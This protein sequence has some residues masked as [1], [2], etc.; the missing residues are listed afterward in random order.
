MAV[1]RLSANIKCR[2]SPKTKKIRQSPP[3]TN[4]VNKIPAVITFL[5]LSGR[6]SA[7]YLV[8]NRETVIGVPEQ[9]MVSK[10]AKTDSQTKTTS[11]R[12]LK[13]DDK[14]DR[15]YDLLDKPMDR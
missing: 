2:L 3:A 10:N 1:Q 14:L 12:P 4:R 7:L 11:S 6:F 15:L 8:I 5:T 9:V 13:G